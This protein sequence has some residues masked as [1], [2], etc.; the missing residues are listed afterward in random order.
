MQL[1]A[2]NAERERERAR[3]RV[4]HDRGSPRSNGAVTARRQLVTF[5]QSHD[6]DS[7]RTRS[8]GDQGL[9][10]FLGRRAPAPSVRPAGDAACVNAPS[11][12]FLRHHLCQSET[13][14]TPKFAS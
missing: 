6:G 2:G 10:N 7:T 14:F 11:S 12:P 4:R 3:A 13:K 9:R 8:H 1:R 5:P